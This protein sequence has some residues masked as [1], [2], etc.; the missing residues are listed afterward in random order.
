M[1]IL[2]GISR[3][4][5]T[6]TKIIIGADGK[7][8]DEKGVKFIIN[9][10]DEFA[11]EEGLR[12]KEKYGGTVVTIT[13]GPEASK[14][15]IRS[16]LA[17]GADR[18]VLIK[19][20]GFFDSFFAAKNIANYAKQFNPEIIFFGRQ[21]VD[22]DSLMVPAMVAEFLGLPS[23]TIVSKLTIDGTKVV[24]E[25]DVVG[26]KEIVETT[27]PCVISAQKGLNEPRY[28]KLPDILKA[29]NKPIEEIT[30]EQLE[31][32]VEILGMEIPLRARKNKIVGDSDQ[33]IAEIVK[34]LHE[35]AKVI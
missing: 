19:T 32:K 24:A 9:P 22:F 1:N 10:Y 16:A 6:A 7:S 23:I 29:K 21:S 35:D 27:L 26:G 17:M 31:P 5:D 13:V 20:E 12:L 14:E 3:V 11:L 15:V 33:E 4:P 18:A 30:P 8:I 25:R 28:P 34:L 2:V